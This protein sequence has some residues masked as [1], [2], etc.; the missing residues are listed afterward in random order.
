RLSTRTS[1]PASRS[2]GTTSRPRVPVPPV[3]RMGDV[4]APPPRM[5]PV[6]SG[7]VGGGPRPPSGGGL[8]DAGLAPPRRRRRPGR[9]AAPHPG[10]NGRG[11]EPRRVAD[12]DRGPHLP[13]HAAVT[14]H[15]TRGTPRRPP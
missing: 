10:R 4:M 13:E 11:R 8:P 7:A 9:L 15:P 3:T 2:R 14:H 6:T 12:H 5:P 1:C